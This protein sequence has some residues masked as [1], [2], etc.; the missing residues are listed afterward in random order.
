MVMDKL[1]SLPNIGPAMESWLTQVGIHTPAQLE[2]EGAVGAYLKIRTLHSNAAN[3]MALYALY[4]ALHQ[5]NC[6]RLAPEVK[7]MLRE[8]VSS[9][10]KGSTGRKA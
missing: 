1:Q 7:V 4:G 2:K 3:L 9:T 10:G 6:L 8:M 5:V